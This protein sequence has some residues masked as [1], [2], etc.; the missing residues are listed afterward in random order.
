M[1]NQSGHS[2]HS[3]VQ[4]HN[5]ANIK[6]KLLQKRPQEPMFYYFAYGSCMCPVDLKRSLG[7]NTHPYVVG[8]GI[9]KDYRLGF[10]VCSPTRNCGVLDIVKDAK[11]NVKG[12]LYQLPWRLSECLDI[13]EGVSQGLY[14]HEVVDIHCQNQVYK[15]VRTYTVVNKLAEEIAPNDWYFNVVL[16]GAITCGLPEEYC[17]HLFNHMYQLQQR[18]QDTQIVRSA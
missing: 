16:R 10:Y 4:P 11:A 1:S 9:L 12:V 14:C 2:H 5:P 6:L 18:H 13:R 17:W 3:W 8:T 15:D 7:E